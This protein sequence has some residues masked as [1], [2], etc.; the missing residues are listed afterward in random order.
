MNQNRPPQIGEIY[1]MKFSGDGCEQSGI[2]PGLVFQ[3]NMG[4]MYSPNIIA[5][6]ITSSLKKSGQPTRWSAC[7]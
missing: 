4:N 5:L 1:L 7:L 3:N 2:R 6:P